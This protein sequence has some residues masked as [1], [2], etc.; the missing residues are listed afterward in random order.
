MSSLPRL[1]S[2][3][4]TPSDLAALEAASKP[5]ILVSPDNADCLCGKSVPN[6]PSWT[7]AN[8]AV[9]YPTLLWDQGKPNGARTTIGD[10]LTSIDASF[11][12]ASVSSDARVDKTSAYGSCPDVEPL[13]IFDADFGEAAPELA[14]AYEPAVPLAFPSEDGYLMHLSSMRAL[15]RPWRWLL[16]SAPGAG[17]AVHVD[18]HATAAWN[19]LIYGRK[20]WALLPPATEVGHVLPS[21][22]PRACS[23][24]ASAD[25]AASNENCRNGSCSC[26]GSCGDELP[27]NEATARAWFAS[28]LPGLRR[29]P[30]TGLVEF[31][32]APGEVLFIPAG[33]WHAALTVGDTA[34][35]GVTANFMTEAGCAATLAALEAGAGAG[36]DDDRDGASGAAAGRALAAAWRARVLAAGL[37]LREPPLRL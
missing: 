14:S 3:C 35:V 32:Q 13:Y 31:E 26:C 34:A 21:R 19:A 29:I 37:P 15:R 24:S 27:P 36:G 30:V 17:F 23:C 4:T 6:W 10:V 7:A 33:W 12:A 16:I 25:A 5:A 20:A 22:A 2:A 18:P 8:L 11:V 1:C 28:V 9:A